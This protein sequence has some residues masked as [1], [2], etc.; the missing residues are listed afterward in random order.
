MDISDAD[1]IAAADRGERIYRAKRAQATF[2]R[3]YRAP[4]RRPFI[5]RVPA[6]AARFPRDTV[7]GRLYSRACQG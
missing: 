6:F 7:G 4:V 1:M 2:R 3:S 5:P